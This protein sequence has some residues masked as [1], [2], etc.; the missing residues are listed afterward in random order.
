MQSILSKPINSKDS[1]KPAKSALKNAKEGNDNK[2]KIKLS[3]VGLKS[4][5]DYLEDYQ[6]FSQENQSY[7]GN[8]IDLDVVKKSSI[9]DEG[10]AQPCKKNADEFAKLNQQFEDSK[11][12][13]QPE[14]VKHG[15]KA[16]FVRKISK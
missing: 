1:A 7:Y 12:E 9:F 2:Y 13:N 16:R 6:N 3:N 15:K 8:S 14:L 11:V 4:L 10:D 5:C